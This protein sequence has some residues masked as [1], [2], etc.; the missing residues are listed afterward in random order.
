MAGWAA[1]A[2][3]SPHSPGP[4]SMT[5]P[6]EDRLPSG[7]IGLLLRAGSGPSHQPHRFLISSP[8]ST[9]T[10][11]AKR[12]E[13]GR[14][15][16]PALRHGNNVVQG[17]KPPFVAM[18]ATEAIPLPHFPSDIFGYMRPSLNP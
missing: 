16:A 6:D 7:I 1:E 8:F 10:G 11:S 9:V 2:S 12:L 13:V 15:V 18:H 5:P 3:G 17:K 4:T 14:F